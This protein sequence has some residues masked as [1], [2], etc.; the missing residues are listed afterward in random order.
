MEATIIRAPK[1]T[2]RQEVP[3]NQ[4]QV[5][6]LWNFHLWLKDIG[7]DRKRSMPK[8]SAKLDRWLKLMGDQ[9][10]ENWHLSHDLLVNIKG[11]TDP[12]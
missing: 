6:D 7:G 11:D 1:G 3:V 12:N 10:L 4:V 5:P 9:V 2:K 8:I